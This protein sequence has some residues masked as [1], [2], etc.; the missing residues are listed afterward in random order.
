MGNL[1]DALKYT[2]ECAALKGP[3]QAEAVKNAAVIR[4]QGGGAP[5]KKAAGKK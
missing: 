5:A 2:Q 1:N 4:S 3:K